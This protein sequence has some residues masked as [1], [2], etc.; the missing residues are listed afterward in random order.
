MLFHQ[1]NEFKF[2]S[3]Q[4]LI[5]YLNSIFVSSPMYGQEIEVIGDVTHAKYSKKGDLYIELSQKVRNSNYSITVFFNQSSV[6]YLLEHCELKSEKE[7]TNKRWKFG[8]IVNFWKREAKYVVHGTYVIPLG[9]SEIE[10]K[11]REILKVLEKNGLLRKVEHELTEL[12]P[13]KK[14]AVVSSPTAAGFGDFLKNINHARFIPVVHLYPAPMQGVNT[15]PGIKYALGA[16]LK[17]KIDYDIVVIIR[18]GGSKSDLMYFDDLELAYLIARFNEKIPVVVGIG[19]EQDRTI[20]DYVSWKSY[21]TPTEVSRDIVNQINYYVDK[22]EFLE[23]DV[24]MY[25]NGIYS[26]TES[27]ISFNT[28]NNLKYYINQDIM[29]CFRKLDDNYLKYN[30]QIKLIFEYTEKSIDINKL[31][32]TANLLNFLLKNFLKDI[33]TFQTNI[34]TGMKNKIDKLDNSLINIFQ[35]LTESSPFAAFLYNG[36]LIKKDEEIVDSVSSLN[37]GE[38]VSL[39]FKDGRADSSIDKI[40]KW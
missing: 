6:P 31:E 27:L 20:P 25:F 4:E 28:V 37:E 30:K 7:L 22:I 19:H 16:I 11:R 35:R 40:Y 29:N 26:R 3:I 8:G 36:V 13:I 24:M 10:K 15:V 18:G 12:E 23:K 2:E 21:S 39:I 32:S 5:E 14:I 33:E 34:L 17:S 38:Q 9:D 1:Q